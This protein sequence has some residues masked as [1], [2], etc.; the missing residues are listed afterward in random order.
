MTTTRK[1]AA[2][3]AADVAGYSRLIG[4][5]EEGTIARLRALRRELID[6]T[7]TKHHGRIFKTTG[8]GILVEFASVVDAVRCA[9]EVQGA[10]AERNEDVP[11]DE[12]IEFRVGINVGD[13]VIDGADI[14]GDGV[15]IAARL[16]GLAEP[17][18]VCVSARAQE[19]TQ[20]KLD[21]TF[22]D[23]GEQNLKNI[24][25]PVRVYKVRLER[26]SMS[27]PALPLPDK[28]S[29]A[30]LPFTNMSGDQE[31]EYFSDGIAEDIIT[32]LS[33]SRSLFVI[34]RNSSFTYKGRAVDVKQV[35]RELG[36]RYVLEGSVRRGGNRVRV[37]AQLIEAD[38]GNHLWAER[39]D[40]DLADV[41]AVQDEITE[42]V[43]IAIEPAVAATER[44]RAVRKPPE[45]LGA[46]EAYQRGLWHISQMS[47]ADYEKAKQLFRRAIDLDPNFGAA[48]SGLARS[49]ISGA[50]LHQ[51]QSVSEALDEGLDLAQRAVTLDP[52]DAVG[53][54]C[55][56]LALT[57][58]G[59]YE[60]GL[61]QSRRALGISPNLAL[62]HAHLGTALLYSGR[63][64]EAI[65]A[66]REALRRIHTTQFVSS[67]IG[68][69][70]SG[71]LLSARV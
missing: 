29:I 66:I 70:Y 7:M 33:H 11:Q 49:T 48:Y 43:A 58:R 57:L 41:F 24:A 40:R 46:W 34:A 52:S 10:M 30:V 14:L 21:I 69:H 63:P 31:Q 2:I 3:L 64:R 51:T 44:Q 56:G 9:V 47:A 71:P 23:I 25:R 4:I 12:R 53:H 13:I 26:A 62:A 1:L 55:I 6:P 37:T 65:D 68:A 18:G 67:E 17:G 45:S 54:S 50:N 59:D 35:G 22:E 16:E 32:L 60:G 36:V 15:N 19:D 38:T 8:D 28:P 39:N 5:D 42:A 20:G 61:A 27:S